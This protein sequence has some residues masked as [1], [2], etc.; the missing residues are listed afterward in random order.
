MNFEDRLLQLVPL[1]TNIRINKNSTLWQR[2]QDSK[3]IRNRVAHTGQRITRAEA[4]EVISMVK[5]WLAFLGSTAELDLSLIGLKKYLESNSISIVNG[6]EA[7][8]FVQR[9]YEK[10]SPAVTVEQE[11]ILSNYRA[12]IVLSYDSYNA[13]IEVK[14]SSLKNINRAIEQVNEMTKQANLIPGRNGYRPIIIFFTVESLP[15]KYKTIQKMKHGMSL[16]VIRVKK[17]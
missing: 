6:R 5:D 11:K 3:Q 8:S 1:A 16:I 14:Y 9:Y 2:Y 17:A 15:E 7:T 13:L 12:D 10:T 4:Q